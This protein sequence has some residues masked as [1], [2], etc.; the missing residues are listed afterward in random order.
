MLGDNQEGVYKFPLPDGR[1]LNLNFN[2]TDVPGA[3]FTV[4]RVKVIDRV[5]TLIR[6]I[7]PERVKTVGAIELSR[8]E[9]GRYRPMLLMELRPPLI[10]KSYA[11]PSG[12][13][14]LRRF[15]TSFVA[16]LGLALLATR[17]GSPMKAASKRPTRTF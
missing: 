3:S 4:S 10:L 14:L 11:R 17:G 5:G 8:N 9:R 2:P 6:S 1:Y 13:S 12:R 7:A 15:V 16:G